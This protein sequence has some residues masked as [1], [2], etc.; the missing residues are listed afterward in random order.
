M[1]KRQK[2]ELRNAAKE[3]KEILAILK[4]VY[5]EASDTFNN[6]SDAWMSGS[7]AEKEEELLYHLYQACDAVHDALIELEEV[8]PTVKKAEPTRGR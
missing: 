3:L 7:Y 4:G 6:H 1:T 8:A 2:D 5:D